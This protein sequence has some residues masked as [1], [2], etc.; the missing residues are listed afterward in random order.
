MKSQQ[1]LLV[2]NNMQTAAASINQGITNLKKT[3]R[4]S[5][6]ASTF[7]QSNNN[8]NNKNKNISPMPH[9]TSAS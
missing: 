6:G 5:G 3:S 7:K 4:F 2:P 9:G 8:P 1:T